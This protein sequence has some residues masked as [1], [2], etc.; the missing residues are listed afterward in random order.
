[1]TASLKRHSGG[2]LAAVAGVAAPELVPLRQSH[3]HQIRR[4][5]SLFL[6]VRFRIGRGVVFEGLFSFGSLSAST[7]ALKGS[8][9]SAKMSFTSRS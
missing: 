2:V 4:R 3:R 8:S 9:C 6:F 7:I 1:M 5:F